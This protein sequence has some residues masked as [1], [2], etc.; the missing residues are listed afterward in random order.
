MSNRELKHLDSSRCVIAKTRSGRSGRKIVEESVENLK[1]RLLS[2]QKRLE[3]KE[4]EVEKLTQEVS[5]ADEVAAESARVVT[6]ADCLQQELENLEVQSELA[7]LCALE[8]ICAEH[9]L[10]LAKEAEMRS[11]EQKRTDAWIQDL[12]DGFQSEK[13]VLLK[14]IDALEKGNINNDNFD[15]PVLNVVDFDDT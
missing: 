13:G 5:D 2:V 1:A 14:R 6:R 10:A 15:D 7:K 12:R 11:A 4:A 8:N 3:A 9:Q